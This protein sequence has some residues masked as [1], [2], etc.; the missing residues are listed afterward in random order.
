MRPLA[1]ARQAVADSQRLQSSLWPTSRTSLISQSSATPILT[2]RT[3]CQARTR[4]LAW[5]SRPT[6][7]S[8]HAW[9]GR[10]VKG[11]YAQVPWRRINGHGVDRTSPGQM[12]RGI[13]IRDKC[14]QYRGTPDQPLQRS[15]QSSLSDAIPN[16]CMPSRAWITGSR[17]QWKAGACQP[18]FQ[19]L[20]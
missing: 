7:T 1:H 16:V 15:V 2:S 14:T 6:R 8:V 9:R 12:S 10:K 20:N 18:L 11:L 3:G 19:L 13:C 5:R 17:E 4:G